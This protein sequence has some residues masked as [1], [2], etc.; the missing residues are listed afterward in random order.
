MTPESKVVHAILKSWGA[1][2]RLRIWRVNTG[3]AQLKGQWVRFGVP[4]QADI[5]GV[6][7]PTGIR[8]EIECK[9]PKGRQS[10]EQKAW[11]A[12]IEKFGGLY[13]LARSVEDVD[14]ALA[15]IG[16]TR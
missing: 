4:G 3:M 15:A 8:L 7:G 11:Q 12:M 6:V 16:I 14:R 5:S 2:P 9:A 10:D 1:H 13:V